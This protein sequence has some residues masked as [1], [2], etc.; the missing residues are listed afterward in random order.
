[1]MA[2]GMKTLAGIPAAIETNTAAGS[3]RRQSGGCFGTAG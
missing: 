2:T 3:N 1:M